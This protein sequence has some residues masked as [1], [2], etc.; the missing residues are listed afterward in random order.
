MNKFTKGPWVVDSV[1]GE[2]MHDIILG[3]QI[4]RMGFPIVIASVSYDEDDDRPI[5]LAQANANAR[6]MSCAPEL[7]AA[8][9]IMLM[10]ATKTFDEPSFIEC[11]QLIG[12]TDPDNGPMPPEM[13]RMVIKKAKGE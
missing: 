7:L 4:P 9:E 1:H 12:I 2:A 6:L 10:V 13:L 11:C 8:C 3:Y 5:D